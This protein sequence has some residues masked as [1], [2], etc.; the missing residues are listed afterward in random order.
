METALTTFTLSVG[1]LLRGGIKW[2]TVLMS[3]VGEEV[4]EGRSFLK[5]STIY[6]A[7]G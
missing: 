2:W 1:A 5:L 6:L 4:I 3:L 7:F